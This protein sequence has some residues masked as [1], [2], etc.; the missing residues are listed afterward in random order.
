MGV[1][2]T[3]PGKPGRWHLRIPIPVRPSRM[4]YGA[5]PKIRCYRIHRSVIMFP[6]R[7]KTL[8]GRE[9]PD[10]HTQLPTL[11]TNQGT[12]WKGWH[13]PEPWVPPPISI[14]D[15]TTLFSTSCC[16]ARVAVLQLFDSGLA[17]GWLFLCEKCGVSLQ[18]NQLT[19]TSRKRK[20][21]KFTAFWG[22]LYFSASGFCYH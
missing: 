4:V 3:S 7:S 18:E 20:K 2:S 6:K 16:D 8:L 5:C 19:T 17:R 22:G 13:P 9:S 21:V 11:P 14:H 12:F 1:L 10:L 15:A